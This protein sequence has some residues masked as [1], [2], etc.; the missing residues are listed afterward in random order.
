MRADWSRDFRCRSVAEGQLPQHLLNQRGRGGPRE[1]LLAG[2][3][4]D[5]SRA[6]AGDKTMFDALHQRFRW[7]HFALRIIRR[8]GKCQVCH[9]R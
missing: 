2:D 4:V 9:Q 6:R 1:L 7:L 8:D 5:K 3:Q